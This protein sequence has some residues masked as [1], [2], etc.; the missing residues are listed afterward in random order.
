MSSY[1]KGKKPNC[2]HLSYIF[3]LTWLR[4]CIR[5][6]YCKFGR[7]RKCIVCSFFRKVIG[8]THEPN[9]YRREGHVK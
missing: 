8:V 6:E 3:R 2:Q 4:I 9:Y 5:D 7:D 1:P